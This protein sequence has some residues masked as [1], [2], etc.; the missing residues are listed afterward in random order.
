MGY[1]EC[2]TLSA[3]LVPPGT[4][5]EIHHFPKDAFDPVHHPIGNTMWSQAAIL[6]TVL[7]TQM[8]MN[9]DWSRWVL[10]WFSVIL[11]HVMPP[12]Y[13]KKVVVL[14]G[15]ITDLVDGYN[16]KPVTMCLFSDRFQAMWNFVLRQTNDTVCEVSE[17]FL[18]STSEAFLFVSQPQQFTLDR[19]LYAQTRI[20][21]DEDSTQ[22]RNGNASTS[23]NMHIELHII[24]YSMSVSQIQAICDKETDQYLEKI[25]KSREKTKFLYT[26]YKTEFDVYPRDCWM[27]HAFESNRTFD[28]LF[29][30]GKAALV[31]Q[32]D[33]FTNNKHW[34]DRM[35][36]PYTLGIGLSGPPGTGK[37][38]LI[39]CMANYLGRHVVA[40]SLKMVQTRMQ[41]L[42]FF[43]ETQYNS[44]NRPLSVGFDK[45]IIVLED[46]D[47]LGSLV[48]K[49]DAKAAAAPS[50]EAQTK[51]LTELLKDQ[52]TKKEV[53]DIV[54][55][56]SKN[57]AAE[58]ITLDDILN[59]WDGLCETPHRILIITSNHYDELDPALV[60]PGRIDLT[61]NMG[62]VTPTVFKDMFFH[63]SGKPWPDAVE[64][65]DSV[66][67]RSPAEIVNLFV[68]SG[69]DETAF[70][71]RLL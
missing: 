41:L 61:L 3:Q 50:D 71:E 46:I 44:Q 70:V 42:Q 6:Q 22:S 48:K 54:T 8:F 5:I 18:S 28:N 32:L 64:V 57:S 40:L 36:I 52:M 2:L 4:Q 60:R 15:K 68:Q 53:D 43:Y 29:F 7:L 33:F 66:T 38:S 59:L 12:Q 35:G 24:S 56:F 19:D 37:T 69:R 13:R 31:S 47:C 23:R 58:T 30:E 21:Y 14:R 11:H 26:L 51:K 45:K 67:G 17:N 20:R 25:R 39:K 49:R 34:Y 27:E 62:R 10:E 9:K 65:P 55:R 63:L 16:C 1:Y